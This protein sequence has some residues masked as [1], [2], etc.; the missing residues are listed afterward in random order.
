[1]S[2]VDREDRNRGREDKVIEKFKSV[3]KAYETLSDP[4][5]RHYYDLYYDQT[6][7]ALGDQCGSLQCPGGARCKQT[8]CGPECKCRST[9]KR[10]NGKKTKVEVPFVK[11]TCLGKL[12]KRTSAVCC[13]HP[14]H[15]TKLISAELQ[16][17]EAVE[18]DYE[19]MLCPESWSKVEAAECDGAPYL[20]E[21]EE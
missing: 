18:V 13:K 4:Q 16:P 2:E 11:G 19:K 15:G 7:E 1:M 21:L 6:V 8:L 10:V 3:L 12:L 9:R 20:E 17:N 14:E 5:Q